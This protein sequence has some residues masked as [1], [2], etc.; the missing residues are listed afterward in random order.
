MAW[1]PG[2]DALVVHV[3]PRGPGA[4]PFRPGYL[5]VRRHKALFVVSDAGP[6]GRL[7]ISSQREQHEVNQSGREA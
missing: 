6:L 2:R 4:T 3:A 5:Y 7:N 1:H